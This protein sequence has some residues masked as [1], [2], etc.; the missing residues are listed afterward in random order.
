MQQRLAIGDLLKVDEVG[1]LA[2]YLSIQRNNDSF[3]A[4]IYKQVFKYHINNSV[5]QIRCRSPRLCA[6]SPKLRVS[7]NERRWTDSACEVTSVSEALGMDK[8]RSSVQAE[9]K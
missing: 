6:K 5:Y 3:C 8:P 7:K 2:L 4:M 9:T 1:L